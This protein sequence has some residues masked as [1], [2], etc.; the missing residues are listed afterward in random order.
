MTTRVEINAVFEE[1]ILELLGRL[2]LAADYLESRLRCAVC[3][4]VIGT[5]SS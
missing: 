4:Q 2:G 5:P 3:Q 1:Q